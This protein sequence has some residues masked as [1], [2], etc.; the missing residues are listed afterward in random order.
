MEATQSPGMSL[1]KGS[2]AEIGVIPKALHSVVEDSARLYPSKVCLSYQ[3]RSFTYGQLDDLAS[4]FASALI[5][6]GLRK[7]DRVG[8]FSPNTP[9][10]VMA[11]FGTLKAGGAVVPC[12]PIYKEKELEYQLRD[13]GASFVVAANDVVKGNDLFASLEACRGRLG[14]KG[15]IAASVT[16]YLPGFKRPLAGLAGFKNVKR[17]DTLSFV[18]LVGESRPLA[19]PTPIDPTT[20]VALLQ[21]TG[22]TTGVSK[23]AMLS[24]ANLYLNAV[25]AS[26]QLPLRFNDIAL[27]VLPLF[28]IYGMTTAMNGPFY[29]GARII[30]L[31]RFDAE[32]VMKTI[33]KYR[34]TSYCGV[35]AMYIA[36]NNN[37][38]QSKYDLRSVRSCISGGAP[39]PV[40]VRKR[41]IE[42]TGAALVEG[43]GLTEASP[44]THCNP[45]GEGSLVREGSIGMPISGTE[46]AVVDMDD[47]KKILPIGQEGELIVKGPQVMLGYW[48]RKEESDNVLKDG[49]LLTGDVARM[50]EDGYFFIVDRKKDM[51]DVGGFKVYPREVEELLFTHPLVKDAAVVG[52]PDEKRGEAVKAFVVLKPEG[53]GKVTEADVIEYCRKNISTYKAPRT[54]VFVD[55]LPKTLVGK[56]LRRQLRGESPT[57]VR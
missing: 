45:I 46:A 49:W 11:Y 6:R 51:I 2:P 3:G 28:H 23:G 26:M 34:V 17:R 8:I 12:S 16:D 48:N 5:S 31:P 39:L 24:H 32:T 35:P 33:E 55:D 38:K 44:V 52:T 53:K 1:R 30:L 41:F 36:I 14:L 4:R 37:P 10:F 57:P 47:P 13:S 40:V 19:A 27:A 9:Q 50:D 20:D 22:G 25:A 43:Y 15:I 18:E 54:V 56:V 7:G 42:I 29:V 21:Y